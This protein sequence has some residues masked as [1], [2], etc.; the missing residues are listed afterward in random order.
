MATNAK[1][2]NSKTIHEGF[3]PAD[4]KGAVSIPI[5]QSSTFAFPSVDEGAA[6]F[7]GVSDGPIYTRLGNPTV[8]ALE[9]CVAELEGGCGAIGTATGMGAVTA[10]LF[11]HLRAGDHLV[12]T[13]PLYG[14]SRG[15]VD[16]YLSR[17]GVLSTFVPAADH[18]ALAAAIRP[19]TRLVYVESPANPTLDMVDIEAAA[20]AAHAAGIP[21]AVDNTFAGPRLQRPIE[22]GADIVLHSMTK[23]LNGHADVVAGVVV[24]REPR[25]LAEC[26]EVAKTFGLTMDPH[27]AWLVLRGIRT[28]GMRVERAQ[29]NAMILAEWLETHPEVAWVRYPGLPSHPQYALALKQ[30]KGPGSVISFELKGGVEAGSR[31]MDEVKLITLAVSLGGVESLIEHPASMTHKGVSVE[32][33][34]KQGITPGLVRLAV[35]CEDVEDIR[36]DLQHAFAQ[37]EAGV[38]A[39]E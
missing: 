6:R 36:A 25:A 10:V 19:E 31:L 28:L 1:G 21:L 38:L 23:S 20:I 14:P 7:A 16:K 35:G 4:H 8:Q 13:H 32:E 24:A 22:L 34:K 27:Q 30:M 33:Q 39:R 37:V 5:Y 18:E 15:I 3:D 17:L 29:A 2:F 11:S 9:R 12:G 26:R